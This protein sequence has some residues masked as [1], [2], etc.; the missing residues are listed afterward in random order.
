MKKSRFTVAQLDEKRLEK[1]RKL[2]EEFGVYLVALEKEFELAELPEDKLK[3]L[4]EAE[5][6]LGVVLLAYRSGQSM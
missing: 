1:V 3:E 5:K 2:E 6:E 4:Q